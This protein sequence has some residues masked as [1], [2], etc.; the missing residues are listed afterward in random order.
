MH[1]HLLPSEP[2]S[3]VVFVHDYLQLVFQDAR[4]SIYNAAELRRGNAT[5]LSEQPG[6]RDELV[7]LIG[8][9]LISASGVP[10]LSLAFQNGAVLVVAKSGDGPEAWAYQSVKGELVVEQNA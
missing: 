4:F 2:L 3:Q 10:S 5:F 1:S 9:P 7:G 6:F 8:Q